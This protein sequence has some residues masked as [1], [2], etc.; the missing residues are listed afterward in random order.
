V[1]RE[2]SLW[3]K[4]LLTENTNKTTATTDTQTKT[5]RRS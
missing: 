5:F 2:N 4:H 1:N 3:S